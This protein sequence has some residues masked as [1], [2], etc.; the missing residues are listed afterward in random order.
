MNRLNLYPEELRSK[1]HAERWAETPIH[2]DPQVRALWADGY[3]NQQIAGMMRMPL[4]DVKLM[5][6]RMPA[7][8][9]V[10]FVSDSVRRQA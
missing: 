3:T 2:I 10:V 6:D 8:S 7:Q 1:A 5:T 4:C 9:R